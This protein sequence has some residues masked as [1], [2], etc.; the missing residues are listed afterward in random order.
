MLPR[1]ITVVKMLGLP[2]LLMMTAALA[3]TATAT[4]T[5]ATVQPDEHVRAPTTTTKEE[6]RLRRRE[7]RSFSPERLSE[8]ER[9]ARVLSTIDDDFRQEEEN[10]IEIGTYKRTE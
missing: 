6:S 3:T 7:G 10:E 9:P 4:A 2:W 8:Q 1:R 5:A